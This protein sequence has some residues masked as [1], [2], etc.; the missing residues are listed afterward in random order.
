MSVHPD[1][2]PTNFFYLQTWNDVNA[3]W[4]PA[5]YDGISDVRL[6]SD[7]LWRPDVL[8]YNRLN[9]NHF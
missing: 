1:L 6:P 2:G 3:K 5:Q 4:D 9:L 7:A 8:L